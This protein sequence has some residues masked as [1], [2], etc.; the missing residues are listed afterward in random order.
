METHSK[1]SLYIP[2]GIKHTTEQFKG[3]PDEQRKSILIIM[4]VF[5]LCD[6]FAYFLT[7]NL[8]ITSGAFFVQFFGTAMF[9][10][11]DENTNISV[12][13]TIRYMIRF[14]KSQKIYPYIALK[15]WKY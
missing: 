8:A 2:Q 3:I 1:D 9:F 4:A 7:K 14:S 6:L 11:R 13:D 15:E 12:A 5:F 10:K